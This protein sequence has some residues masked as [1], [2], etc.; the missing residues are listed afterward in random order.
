MISIA[1]PGA[2]RLIYSSVLSRVRRLIVPTNTFGRG[3][4]NQRFSVPGSRPERRDQ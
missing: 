1:I 2:L 3:S 4:M